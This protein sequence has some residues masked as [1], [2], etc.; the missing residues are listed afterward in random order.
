MYY[1]IRGSLELLE[2]NI[3]VIEA[4]GV[5]YSLT[6][7]ANTRSKLAG[8]N[9]K[10]K[11]NV[12]LL[13]HLAVREDGIEL[14]GFYTDEEL[15][16]FRLL[17]SVSGIGPKAALSILGSM[18]AENLAIAISRDDKK[19]IAKAPGIGPKTA[20]RIILELKDKHKAEV[21][22][23]NDDSFAPAASAV[24][25]QGATADAIDALTVLGYS[26]S[27]AAEA[28]RGIP[29]GLELEDIIREALKKLLR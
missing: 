8:L 5:G 21:S 23:E 4:A 15:N 20:A 1:Y 3:A 19:A 29:A 14:F 27:A 13:T 10:Q 2:A 18:T 26:R 16:V 28:V 11:E 9:D 22:A 7:S 12:K 25:A 17:I 6:I 24:P